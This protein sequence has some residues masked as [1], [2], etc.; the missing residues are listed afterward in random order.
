MSQVGERPRRGAFGRALA[1]LV[2]SNE[3]IEAE[4]LQRESRRCGAT[5]LIS[6][7]DR[8]QV[9]IGGTV[10]AVTLQPRGT[11][12]W[13]QVDLRDGSGV[14]TLV[15]MGRRSIPGI[16]PGTRLKV[17][18]RITTLEGRRMM[19]NPRYELLGTS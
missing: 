17:D 1:R 3:Q 12:N 6:C 10:S 2:S 18:G 15:W 16:T 14:L 9:T 19:F 11:T 4:D 13:L 5:P 8:T 7:T